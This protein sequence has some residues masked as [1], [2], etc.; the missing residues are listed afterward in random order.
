M[1]FRAKTRGLL[2]HEAFAYRVMRRG[3][4]RSNNPHL[5]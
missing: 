1:F 4:W 2:D 3:P 5:Q